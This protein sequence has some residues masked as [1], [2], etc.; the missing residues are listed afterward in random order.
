MGERRGSFIIK[1][2]AIDMLPNSEVLPLD[3]MSFQE[4]LVDFWVTQFMS[5]MQEEQFV[6]F[7]GIVIPLQTCSAMI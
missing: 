4:C 2:I 6:L 5:H 1:E 7:G 3:H